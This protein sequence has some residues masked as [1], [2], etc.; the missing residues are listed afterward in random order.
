M[1][2]LIYDCEIANAIAHRNEPIIPNIN[3][4]KGWDDLQG[5]GIAC[6]TAYDYSMDQYRVFFEDNL[7]DLDALVDDSDLIVGFNNNRFDDDL[8]AVNGIVI[9]PDKTYDILQEIWYAAG[10]GYVRRRDA[11]EFKIHGGYSLDSVAEVNVKVKK[12]G[13]GAHA[14]ILWQQNKRGQVVDYGLTDTWLTKKVFDKILT[15][16]K[17][18]DPK[19]G[20]SLDLV[21][22]MD[23]M[24][25]RDPTP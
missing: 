10:H 3:Y 12:S 16:A 2:I 19:S 9:D 1:K 14:P 20:R 23:R 7:N 21:K 24:P 17:L 8:M 5:M 6:V 4:C 22:P 25:E 18:I 13:K 11:F 15:N